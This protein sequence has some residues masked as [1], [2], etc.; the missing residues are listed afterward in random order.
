MGK[1]AKPIEWGKSGK[2]VPGDIL[3]NPLYVEN[4]E[5]GTHIFPIVWVLFSH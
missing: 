4:L 3:Q 1:I 2:L 5:I